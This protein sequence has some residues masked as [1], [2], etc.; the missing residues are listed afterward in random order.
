MREFIKEAEQYVKEQESGKKNIT[1]TVIYIAGSGTK[2]IGF[3]GEQKDMADI[4]GLDLERP[5]EAYNGNY[6]KDWEKIK[7][8]IFEASVKYKEA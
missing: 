2:F 1:E 7:K 3:Y 5:K 4:V 6:E 8:M